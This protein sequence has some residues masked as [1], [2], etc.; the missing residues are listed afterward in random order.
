MK[1]KYLISSN[2]PTDNVMKKSFLCWA[3]FQLQ[4]NS[5]VPQINHK[6]KYLSVF[7]KDKNSDICMM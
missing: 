7:P 3:D 4:L 2:G 1:E 6:H 5:L